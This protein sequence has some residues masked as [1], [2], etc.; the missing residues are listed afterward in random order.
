MEPRILPVP[1][2]E[3]VENF[4]HAST[5]ELGPNFPA[6][7]W[8]A[9]ALRDALRSGRWF[10]TDEAGNIVALVGHGASPTTAHG[11]PGM[12]GGVVQVA[13]TEQIGGVIRHELTADEMDHD[14]I[15]PSSP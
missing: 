4:I 3:Q 2:T 15:K 8:C 14:I 13:Q 11:G 9:A 1:T 7:N 6:L 12:G 5:L 10:A